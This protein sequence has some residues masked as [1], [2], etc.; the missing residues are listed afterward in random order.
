[1]IH[2][3]KEKRFHEL[4][5]SY[6]QPSILQQIGEGSYGVAYL[7]QNGSTQTVVK[8]LKSKRIN[9]HYIEKFQQEISFL[10]QLQALPVP[11]II[12]TGYIEKAPY[13]EMSFAPGHTFEQAIFENHQSYTLSEVFMYTKQLLTITAQI[14]ANNIVHRDLRIPNILV[15]AGQLTIIDFGL[16]STIDNKLAI[17]KI[18]NPKKAKHPVSDLY[19]IGHFMLFLLYSNFEPQ[20]KKST[21]WQQELQ[22]TPMLQT[23]IEKLLMLQ[24]PFPSAEEALRAL[25]QLIEEHSSLV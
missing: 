3:L 16:A 2:Y 5:Q 19:Q 25:A 4:T 18:K 7:R 1:M 6:F 23:Y 12:Q 24:A 11:R 8:R 20:T 22:L 9:R 21:T 17:E 14:H 13:Y 15:N 10:Q